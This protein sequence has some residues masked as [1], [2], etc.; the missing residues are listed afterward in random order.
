MFMGIGG[1]CKAVFNLN[2]PN[3]PPELRETFGFPIA[4]VAKIEE[5]AR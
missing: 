3:G 4:Q 5:S 2:C 1:R